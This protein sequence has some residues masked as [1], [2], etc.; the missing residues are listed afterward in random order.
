V[1]MATNCIY[2]VRMSS[3]RRFSPGSHSILQR[4]EV[5]PIHSMGSNRGL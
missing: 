1:V 5:K 3:R 4:V 2:G